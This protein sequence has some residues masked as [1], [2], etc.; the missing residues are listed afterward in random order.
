MIKQW[1]F[2]LL[3]VAGPLLG[4]IQEVNIFWRKEVCLPQC[5]KMLE[6]RLRREVPAISD[7][8][9]YSGSGTATLYWKPQDKVSLNRRWHCL[10]GFRSS[11]EFPNGVCRGQQHR[12]L[13][14]A[15]AAQVSAH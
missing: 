11:L 7:I 2:L 3:G 14:S 1:T 4:E 5:E 13:Q 12:H 15:G 9:M 8:R 6:S 10:P